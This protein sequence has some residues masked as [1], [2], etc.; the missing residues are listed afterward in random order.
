MKEQKEKRKHL[1]CPYC[2]EKMMDV[3]SPYCQAC[4]I[5]IFYC[6]KCREPLPR[7]NR[8]CPH[9]GAEIQG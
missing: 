3:D 2:D 1:F 6:I 8:V 9:C 5:T 4:Q 7:D